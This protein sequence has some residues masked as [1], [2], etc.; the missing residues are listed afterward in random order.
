MGTG[1][2][3]FGKAAIT[4]N[5]ALLVGS[6]LLIAAAGKSALVPFS[7]WLRSRDGRTD[8]IK[9]YIL[10]CAVGAPRCLLAAACE[11]GA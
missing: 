10:W 5:Q 1:D 7:G 6:L 3:P 11:P 9:C 8:A 4:S 2:W